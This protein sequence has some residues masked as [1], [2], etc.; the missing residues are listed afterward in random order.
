[1]A[2]TGNQFYATFC[3]NILALTCGLGV[4]WTSA[5]IPF[6]KSS[7]SPLKSGSITTEEASLIG[8]SLTFGGIFGTLV[9]GYIATII[10]RKRTIFLIALPQILGWSLILFAESSRLLMTFRFLIGFSGGGTFNLVSGY[11][12]E[13]TSVKLVNSRTHFGLF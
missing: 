2:G 12:T 11:T 1:M 3:A 13:I 5:A 9:F 4:G 7:E 10:G 8:S 6:L